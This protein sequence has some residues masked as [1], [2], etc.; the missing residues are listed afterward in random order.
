[1]ADINV[2][3][4]TIDRPNKVVVKTQNAATEAV[5]DTAQK[6]I[7]VPTYADYK[8]H[9]EIDPGTG[10]DLTVTVTK[11]NLFAANKDLTVTVATGGPAVIEL[12]EGRFG[13]KTGIEVT[14][15][16]AS[17]EALATVGVQV[18]HIE[19]V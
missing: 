10:G 5:V 1:M 6:F 4:T 9:L 2:T 3:N 13:N 8:S 14:I 12:E 18:A 11:G 17:G 7:I 16:P 15:T 19:T